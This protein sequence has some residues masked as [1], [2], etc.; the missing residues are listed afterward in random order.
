MRN[1]PVRSI[2]GLHHDVAEDDRVEVVLGADL[3]ELLLGLGLAEE[4]LRIAASVVMSLVK[5]TA[6]VSFTVRFSASK[7]RVVSSRR[8]FP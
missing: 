1:G 2:G 7:V 5:R 6:G 3:R 4:L 8:T